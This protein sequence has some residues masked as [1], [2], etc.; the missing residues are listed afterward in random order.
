MERGHHQRTPA[1]YISIRASSTE[2]S[3][4]RYRSMIAALKWQAAQLRHLQRDLSSL[5]M[6][7]PLIAAS[8]RVLAIFR[9]FVL[10]CSAQNIRLRIQKRVQ[11]LFH[12]RPHHRAQMR[13]DLPVVD[14]YHPAQRLRLASSDCVQYPEPDNS[15]PDKF[16]HSLPPTPLSVGGIL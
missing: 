11:H 7:L 3:R 15:I 5:G 2:V 4:R 9:P 12:R 13:S 16:D 8:P 14:L 10:P 6:Q 1:R